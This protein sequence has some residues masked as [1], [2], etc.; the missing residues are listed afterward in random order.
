MF[1]VLTS[2]CVLQGFT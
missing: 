2:L 1:S